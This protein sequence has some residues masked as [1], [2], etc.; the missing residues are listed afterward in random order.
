M[1]HDEALI[2]QLQEANQR[3]KEPRKKGQGLSSFKG[4]VQEIHLVIALYEN[5]DRLIELAREAILS[6]AVCETAKALQTTL[7]HGDAVIR[8]KDGT[9]ANIQSLEAALLTLASATRKET[10]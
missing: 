3:T 2:A 5:S 7:A 4:T 6:R 8:W 10:A 1:T 9:E